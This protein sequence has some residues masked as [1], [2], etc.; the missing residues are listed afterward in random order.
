MSTKSEVEVMIPEGAL[1]AVI[2][3]LS[4]RPY[5]DVYQLIGFLGQEL[6]D[7]RESTTE[8]PVRQIIT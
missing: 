5:R 7:A 2:E 1:L 6:T 4:H 8:K 3:E